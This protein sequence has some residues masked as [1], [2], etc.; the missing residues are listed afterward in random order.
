MPDTEDIWG[1][2]VILIGTALFLWRS[3]RKFDRTNK[4]GIEQFNGYSGKLFARLG[5][6]ILFVLALACV[7]GGVIGLA[8]VHHSTWGWIVL[9]P[10]FGFWI[11]V[12]FFARPK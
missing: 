9:L 10:L 1:I 3:K 8:F 5:D 4:A 7:M 11:F 12:L 6:G 2:A